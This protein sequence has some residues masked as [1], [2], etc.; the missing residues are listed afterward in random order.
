MTSRRARDNFPK[1]RCMGT[2]MTDKA[3]PYYA[4]INYEDTDEIVHNTARMIQ[5]YGFL[6]EGERFIGI[7]SPNRNE[8]MITDLAVNLVAGATVP[9]YQALG[10]EAS[11][12]ILEE[13][14]LTTFFGAAP[15]MLRFVKMGPE[16]TGPVKNIVCFDG[17]S[18]ELAAAA[19]DNYTCYDYWKEVASDAV[20]E[21]SLDLPAP[22]MDALFTLSYTS[23]TTGLP[24]GVMIT[25]LNMIA[26]I[27]SCDMSM[28][29]TAELDTVISYLPLA[30]VFGRLSVYY[31]FVRGGSI[32]NFGGDVR[33]L[34]DDL[35]ILKPTIF[36]AVPRVLNRVYDAIN[37]SVSESNW[38]KRLLF[39]KAVKSK[40][41][42]VRKDGKVTSFFYD[43]V[44]FS[45]LKGKLG[46]R[47]RT[48]V[49][50]SAPI[51]S[52]V[53]EFFRIGFSCNAVEGYGQSESTGASFVTS[54]Y[55]NSTGHVG[56][57]CPCI[58]FKLED[59]PDMNYRSTDKPYPRGEIL[60]RG[61]TIFKGYYKQPEK[62]AETIDKDGWLHTGDVGAIVEGGALK[63]I[64]R[65]KNIFKLSQ[66]EYI[67]PEKVERVYE[68][69]PMVQQ[70]FVYGDSLR[71]NVV[72]IIVPDEGEVVK[73]GKDKGID[74]SFAELCRHEAVR[75]EVED[76]MNQAAKAAKLNSLEQVKGNFF[77]DHNVWTD[78]DLLTPTMKL[79]RHLAK[80]RYQE[81]LD[82]L[83]A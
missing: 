8:F 82:A 59:V 23:G 55:D 69:C 66:G 30:H 51:S 4:W 6:S 16:V 78:Q 1:N 11:K 50:G 37:K 19:G 65:K 61:T 46:G 58:E 21:F 29:A 48:I 79:K 20:K 5:K 36:P 44:V 43:K 35:Q 75:K 63:I 81:Q 57:P 62:T 71:N 32:G 17:V 83:Y 56:G 9:F 72:A 41:S 39:S 70:I 2:K 67:A 25:N 38:V 52:D 73:L 26:A 18:E 15:D 60:M 74:G 34:A 31:T 54:N 64:D 7:V 33:K 76:E 3:E 80:Q 45:K 53:L 68:T 14:G 24:K 47:V 13:T 22:E 27:V 28:A 49:T 42:T 77:L 12:H 10:A 40:T